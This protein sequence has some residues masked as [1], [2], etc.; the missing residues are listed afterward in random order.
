MDSKTL[1]SAII[2]AAA[3]TTLFI[4]ANLAWADAGVVERR[5]EVGAGIRNALRTLEQSCQLSRL[6]A[7]VSALRLVRR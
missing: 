5:N 1:L 3:L 6:P 4:Y 2:T 7:E